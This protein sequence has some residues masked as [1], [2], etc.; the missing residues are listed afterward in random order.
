MVT[1]G[2]LGGGVTGMALHVPPGYAI[3][4]VSAGRS[5]LDTGNRASDPPRRERDNCVAGLHAYREK[6]S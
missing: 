6:D 1:L 3:G 4:R 5:S 2:V